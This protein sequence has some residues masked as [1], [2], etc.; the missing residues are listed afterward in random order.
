MQHTAPDATPRAFCLACGYRLDN[1]PSDRCPECGRHF[2]IHD[3]YTTSRAGRI[4]SI[5]VWAVTRK[6][7]LWVRAPIRYICILAL[8]MNAFRVG[9]V[10]VQLLFLSLAFLAIGVAYLPRRLL[11]RLV[12]RR[13]K[14]PH[15][16]L[17]V[18]R[19]PVR[20]ARLI[21]MTT[22]ALVALRIPFYAV[23]FISLPALQRTAVYEFEIRPAIDPRP[24]HLRVIGILPVRSVTIGLGGVDVWPAFGLP[25]FYRPGM[26]PDVPE[27]I[28]GPW[29]APDYLSIWDIDRL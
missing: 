22:F 21:F 23:F 2:D 14:F 12:V 18:D 28:Y 17:A 9:F 4:S 25:L 11:R 16:L 3:A 26:S 1:L 10:T 5:G 24:E 8:L 6:P 29:Y 15:E 13:H 27:H 20:R 7:A 19:L